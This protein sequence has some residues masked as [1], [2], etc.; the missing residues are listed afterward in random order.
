MFNP[1]EF[2]PPGLVPKSAYT[3]FVHSIEPRV[4]KKG[5][6]MDA[7]KMEIIAPLT[8]INV[9]PDGTM[10]QCNVANIEINTFLTYQNDNWLGGRVEGLKRI[11]I[12]V[13]PTY[14]SFES[15][16]K[17]LQE[18]TKLLQGMCFDITVDSEPE[19]AVRPLTAEEFAKG[20]REA[21]Q[22]KGPD[23]KPLILRWRAR[24]DF[25]GI[26]GNLRKKENIPD[27]N[28]PVSNIMPLTGIATA[29][30]AKAPTMVI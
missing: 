2:A 30:A 8:A 17:H 26:I 9:L 25:S 20:K 15:Y 10:Q 13:H 23:G 27:W 1:N 24:G 7:F 12:K 28:Q 5:N 14:D 19:Y 6:P 21:E 22:I 3:V 16:V 4:S 29:S 11:G 18:Q